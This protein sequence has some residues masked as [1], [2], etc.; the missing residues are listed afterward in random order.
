MKFVRYLGML[1]WGALVVGACGKKSDEPGGSEDKECGDSVCTD[2]QECDDAG[3]EPVCECTGAYEGDACELCAPGYEEVDDTCQPIEVDC[4]DNPCGLRGAC[5]SETGKADYCECNEFLEGPTCAQCVEGYQDNDGDDECTMG[6]DN[7]ELPIDCEGFW[8]CDDT[9]GEAACVCPVGSA[10]DECELCQEGYA[11]QGDEPCYEICTSMD[12]ECTA[13]A[14]CFDDGGRQPGECVCPTGYTG[15]D[16]SECEDGF[17]KSGDFCVRTDLTG[18]DL[19]TLGSVRG[20]NTVIG[21]DSATGTKT[22]LFA[23]DGTPDGLVY[24]AG[25]ET[26]YVANYQG[27]HR[28]DW[29][30]GE[31]TL[32]VQDQIGHGR[33][34]AYDTAGDLLYSLRSSDN[35]LFSVDPSDDSSADI[36][37]TMTSWVWDATYRAQDDLIYLVR[38][39]GLTPTIHSVDPSDAAATEI[40][41]VTGAAPMGS[42]SAGG[43]A[44][45]ESGNLAVL[46]RDLLDE[47]AALAHACARAADRMGFEGYEGAPTT[48]D[49]QES[50]PVTSLESQM[51]SGKELVIYRSYSGSGDNVITIDVDNPDAFICITTYQEDLAVAIAADAQWAGGVLYSYESTITGSVAGGY[52]GDAVL[53]ASGGSNVDLSALEGL[54]QAFRVLSQAEFS[55]RRM[56]SLTDP[57]GYGRSEGPYSLRVLSLPNLAEVTSVPVEGGFSGGL[58]AY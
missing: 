54:L 49:L 17:E 6:C 38:S 26:L 28:T 56:P 11:R 18:F 53:Q 31:V 19:L 10:G 40:G 9:S 32:M 8:V 22:P 50:A 42:S 2:R 43:L 33:P 36:A 25:S 27:V 4:D 57:D 5:V 12:I 13:P 58:S 1:T 39:Q 24:D 14:R 37:S 15:Q 20:F 7:P 45:L 47:E 48:F 34:L 16:C 35:M 23:V 52:A 51:A 3:R 46:V 55:D 44:A 29:E 41:S 30:T 21:L